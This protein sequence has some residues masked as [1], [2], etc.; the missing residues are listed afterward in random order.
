M[1]HHRLRGRHGDVPKRDDRDRSEISEA[2]S[3]QAGNEHSGRAEKLARV[4]RALLPEKFHRSTGETAR[5]DGCA[6]ADDHQ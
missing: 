3:R 5:D 6:N 1:N 2:V 4:K